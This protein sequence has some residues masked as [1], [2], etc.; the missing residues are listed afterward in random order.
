MRSDLLL[1]LKFYFGKDNILRNKGWLESERRGV[2]V[3]SDGDPT[4]WYTYSIIDVLER[5]LA[6]RH[7]VFEYGGGYSTLWYA[8]RVESVVAVESSK[9]WV[10]IVRDQLP[11]TGRIVYR[12]D[13][14][15]YVNE[16]TSHAP[17]DV[18]V[19]DGLCRPDCIDPAIKSLSS[20][21]IIIWDD[22]EWVDESDY[23]PLTDAGFSVL[24]F[25]GLKALG[26]DYKCT[27]VWYRDSNCLDL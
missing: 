20:E 11:T 27:A 19:I 7:R 2:P 1:L 18:V 6:E 24:R 21:G 9:E 15:E 10:E 5:R 17:V 25:H 23:R 3:N 14:D 4:P 22:F 13:R 16:V 8:D 26:S 12:E